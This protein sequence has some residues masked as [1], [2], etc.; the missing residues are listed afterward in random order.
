MTILSNISLLRKM[1]PGIAVAATFAIT[2]C[3]PAL[4]QCS[5]GPG[6]TPAQWATQ[7]WAVTAGDFTSFT[8]QGGSPEQPIGQPKGIFSSI[9]FDGSSLFAM[10]PAAGAVVSFNSGGIS[11]QTPGELIG[12]A[13][14]R[15]SA[16]SSLFF[17]GGSVWSTTSRGEVIDISH[18]GRTDVSLDSFA[19]VAGATYDGTYMWFSSGESLFAV[20]PSAKVGDNGSLIGKFQISNSPVGVLV[21]DGQFIWAAS[22]GNLIQFDVTKNLAVGSFAIGG[23]V[24][25]VLFD[26]IYLWIANGDKVIRFD[27]AKKVE[28]PLPNGVAGGFTSLLFEGNTVWAFRTGA[29]SATNIRACDG[30]VTGTKTLP[31]PFAQAAFDGQHTWIVY[32]S[33][34]GGDLISIR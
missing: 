7:D 18:R 9:V 6:G 28:V 25:S 4:A 27:P 17:A 23:N 20:R 19:G 33:S 11:A 30:I 2:N 26:G 1:L 3:Q 24:S 29:M 13:V 5:A 21:F 15:V 8:V 31:A 32:Q 34:P 10:N 22:A 12:V 16:Q 14:S